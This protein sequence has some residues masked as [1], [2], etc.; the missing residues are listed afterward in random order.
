MMV[1]KINEICRALGRKY[2]R[3]DKGETYLTK[4]KGVKDAFSKFVQHM[5]DD[6]PWKI[7]PVKTPKL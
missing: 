1:T 5:K 7:D 2:F 3:T 6:W 4:D